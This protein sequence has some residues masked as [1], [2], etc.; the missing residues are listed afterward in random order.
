MF[1]PNLK[2]AERANGNA[3]KGREIYHYIN[4]PIKW[5]RIT[6]VVVAINE[7]TERKIL[8][9]DD[10]SGACI[11]CVCVARP[12]ATTTS[13]T[14]PGHLDQF[15]VQVSESRKASGSRTGS[16]GRGKGK[17]DA[18]GKDKGNEEKKGKEQPST[19]NPQI[20]WKEIDVGSVLKIKGQITKFRD[21]KQ[22]EAIKIDV[23]G[24]TE[25]EVKCW[26]EVLNFRQEVLGVPWVVSVED[27]ERCRWEKERSHRRAKV[28]KSSNARGDKRGKESRKEEA[29][30]DGIS[31]REDGNGR[32]KK[33][34]GAMEDERRR[35][36]EKKRKKE[37]EEGLDPANKINYPSMAMRRRVAGKYDAL[38]I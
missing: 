25:Q 27:E 1:L 30:D 17:V 6:G 22:V 34:E 33:R 7:F 32:K 11:E 23:I 3:H 2:K 28:G 36:Y 21:M 38:G 37:K 15:Q 20:P 29:R 12:S 10:S 19:T 14:V 8:T 18:K 16:D 24:G 35:G 31:D 26:D 4:H 5:V 13:T 9:V